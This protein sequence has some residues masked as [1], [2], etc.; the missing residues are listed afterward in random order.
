MEFVIKGFELLEPSTTGTINEHIAFI[1]DERQ[2]QMW[3]NESVKYRRFKPYNETI[4]V[5]E[6][7]AALKDFQ[8]AQIKAKA[9]QKLTADERKALGF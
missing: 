1:A 7:L 3:V 2:A 5:H 9:L 8:R 6:N 4:V